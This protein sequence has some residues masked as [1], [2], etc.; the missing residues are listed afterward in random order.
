MKS[1][2]ETIASVFAKGDAILESKKIRAR[3]IRMISGTASSLCAAI[4]VGF[5]IMRFNAPK[6]TP[7]PSDPEI[8]ATE[9][10]VTSLTTTQNSS[11]ANTVTHTNASHTTASSVKSEVKTSLSAVQNGTPTIAVTAASQVSANL[12]TASV[13]RPDTVVTSTKPQTSANSGTV[14]TLPDD[15]RSKEM[16]KLSAFAMSFITALAASPMHVSANDNYRLYEQNTYEREIIATVAASDTDLNG[17]G[18]FDI[19]DCYKLFVYTDGYIVDDATE[20]KINQVADYNNDGRISWDTDALL[21]LKYYL[22]TNPLD[23]SIFN[24]ENYEDPEPT[25]ETKARHDRMIEEGYADEL[26]PESYYFT[27]NLNTYMRHYGTGYGFFA[28]MVKNGDISPDVNGD[29]AFD[30]KDCVDYE[31]FLENL[32]YYDQE[33]YTKYSDLVDGVINWRDGDFYV[34]DSSIQTSGSSKPF[35]FDLIH[36]PSATTKR[37]ADVFGKLGPYG[38]KFSGRYMAYSYLLDNPLDTEYFLTEYYNQ[39]YE[40]A[41]NYDINASFVFAARTSENIEYFGNFDKTKFSSDFKAYC[42]DIADGKKEV[43]DLNFDGVIDS[44]DYD[45]AMW[46]VRCTFLPDWEEL[47][48][49]TDEE[50]TLRKKQYEYFKTKCDINGDGKAG[51]I[52]DMLLIQCYILLDNDDTFNANAY[53]DY[54]ISRKYKSSFELLNDIDIDRNGDANLDGSMDMGDVVLIMQSQA[55]PDKYELT[56]KGKFNADISDTGNGIT[57]GDAKGIQDRLLHI[58]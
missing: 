57:V 28:D 47:E 25:E 36:L 42:Q 7:A 29:G 51:D 13:K 48:D 40:G 10:I 32:L 56:N 20:K 55:N 37:C 45:T 22:M 19:D 41:S 1:Y 6:I 18:K 49:D 50:N 21:L 44:F 30:M 15:E 39:F 5:G 17:N 31:I 8:I 52:Y 38:G 16:K 33:L 46:R 27:Q 14:T 26:H 24:M 12:T 4:I 11:E 23:T 43:P 9:S 58:G 35:D 53:E 54:Q 2:E 3:R 34:Y